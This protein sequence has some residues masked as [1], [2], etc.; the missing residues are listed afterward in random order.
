MSDILYPAEYRRKHR[1]QPCDVCDNC[2]NQN[3]EVCEIA[4]RSTCRDLGC[5]IETQITRDRIQTAKGIAPNGSQ[6][7]EADIQEARKPRIHFGQIAC[8]NQVMKSAQH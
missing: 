1:Q 4:L 3:D 8:S 6:P 7:T 2:V 5:G